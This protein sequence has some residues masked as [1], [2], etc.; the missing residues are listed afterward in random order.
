MSRLYL[1][2]EG[3]V[4]P[5]LCEELTRFRRARKELVLPHTAAPA[6]LY[7]LARPYA[8]TSGSLYLTVNGREVEPIAPEPAG[9]YRWWE[10]V[11]PAELLKEGINHIELWCDSTAMGGWSLGLEA[12]HAQPH[13]WLSDDGGGTWRNSRMGYLNAVGG[14]YV[15]RLRLQ[16]GTDPL[17]PPVVFEQ[18]DDV[19]LTALRQALPQAALEK[20]PDLERVRILSAWLAESWEHTNSARGFPYAP[21]DAETI[22]AWGGARQGHNGQRPVAMCVHYAVAL[23][24]ACQAVGLAARCAALTGSLHGSDGHFVTEVWLD[25][26][27]KWVMVDPNSDAI[28]WRQG[29]P[30]SLEEIQPLGGGV[31]G[32]IEW[33]RGTAFQRTFP[34]MVE[35]IR[36]NLARGVCFGCRS[37]WYR[38]DFLGRSELSPP[39]HGSLVYCE[40]GLV[41]QAGDQARGFGMFPY[42]AAPAYFSAPPGAKN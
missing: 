34:H 30:L 31:E 17:P 28:C 10:T 21:W 9:A 2:E 14:E 20:R 7:I 32:L 40:T 6:K 4:I 26:W 22:I 25:E 36:D 42:F 37:V 35:F 38:A 39:G 3:R 1:S 11:V 18:P 29:V 27:A 33:G 41:W 23:A 5:S 24:S 15:V 8:A 12:S 13:S 16:E 19:R